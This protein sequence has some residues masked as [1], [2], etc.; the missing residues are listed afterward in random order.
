[1]GDT[2]SLLDRG[3]INYFSKIKEITQ[4]WTHPFG[5]NLSC[6]VCASY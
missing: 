4:P 6:N 3:I 2:A 1:V 5:G